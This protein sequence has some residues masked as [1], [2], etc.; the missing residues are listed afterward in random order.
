M[1]ISI[2]QH[3]VNRIVFL[4]FF[5]IMQPDN[6][7]WLSTWNYITQYIYLIKLRG[8]CIFQINYIS[9]QDKISPCLPQEQANFREL[10][11][12]ASASTQSQNC[13]SWCLWHNCH[14]MESLQNGCN[15][16]LEW[17]HLFPLIS[18]RAVSLA[19]CI[20]A[21]TLTLVVNGPLNWQVSGF[22]TPLNKFRLLLCSIILP[23]KHKIAALL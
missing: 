18:M 8:K 9:L 3:F 1:D 11:H 19:S 6:L 16:I 5:I 20:A 15:P 21:L 14:W 2:W 12:Q 17:V 4:N 23:S 22:W 13:D 10:L 7:K